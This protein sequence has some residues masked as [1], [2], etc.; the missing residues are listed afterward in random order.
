MARSRMFF[1]WMDLARLVCDETRMGV[2]AE[3]ILRMYNRNY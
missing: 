2:D 1:P 3:Q